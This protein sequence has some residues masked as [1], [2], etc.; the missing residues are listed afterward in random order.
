MAALK[1]FSTNKTGIWL[2]SEEFLRI[3]Q[4]FIVTKVE[5]WYAR[6]AKETRVWELK[7]PGNDLEVS[8]AF[9]FLFG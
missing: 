9:T 5:W 8:T 4:L 2:C 1:L 6:E 3:L 7:S